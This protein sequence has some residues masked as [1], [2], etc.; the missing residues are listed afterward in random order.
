MAF[1]IG[2]NIVSK[3][4]ST[5]SIIPMAVKDAFNITGCTYEAYKAGGRVEAVDKSFDEVGTGIIWAGGIPVSKKVVDLSLYKFAGISPEVDA[6]VVKDNDYFKKALEYAPT[7][8]IKQKLQKAGASVGTTKAL[9]IAKFVASMVMTL[10]AYA[11]FTKLKQKF[12]RFNI[13]K[14]F[15]KKMELEEQKNKYTKDVF[16]DLNNFGS[17]SKTNNNPSFGSGDFLYNNVK[18]MGVLDLGITGTRLKNARTEG[19]FNEYAIKEGSFLFFA[20]VADKPIKKGLE[21]FSKEVFK[22]PISLD[23]KFLSSELSEDILKDKKMQYEIADFN[24]KFGK[25]SNGLYDFLFKNQNHTVVSAAKK[26]GIIETVKDEKGNI[27][28]NTAS[29]IDKTEI[30]NLGKRLQEYI[31]FSKSFDIKKYVNKLQKLKIAATTISI[32]TCCLAL[33]YCVPKAMY[34]YRNKHQDG[35]KDFHVRTEYEKELM[36][37]RMNSL[38]A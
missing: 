3:L 15:N 28:I 19:E 32:G 10:A 13:E 36:A 24:K 6:R 26:S 4:G 25:N 34:H 16:S 38:N 18:N 2:P 27:K 7:K 31:D 12:T 5:D 37:K 17:K 30:K 14:E 11:G 23:S 8:D 1:S 20:Y 35:N 33:G 9:A 21:K 22:M 29:Y